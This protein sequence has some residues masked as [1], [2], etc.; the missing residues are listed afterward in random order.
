MT[1]STVLSLFLFLIPLLSPPCVLGE[2]PE[3]FPHGHK[4][5]SFTL[6]L[7]ELADEYPDL[8]HLSSLAQS[9]EGRDVWLM[10]ISLLEKEQRPDYPAIL[11]TAGLEGEHLLGSE[12]ALAYLQRLVDELDE[13]EAWLKTTTV[14]LIPRLNPDAVEY[15]FKTPLRE[16][17]GNTKPIDADRDG[18]I[19]EDGPDDLNEDHLITWMRVK[20]PKG[21]YI[22]H[23]DEER[24]LVEADS[25]QGEKGQWRLL[26]EGRDNDN[27]EKWNEDPLGEINFNRQF[28][29]HYPWFEAD[30]GVFQL[31][32]EIPRALADFILEHRHIAMVFS[33]ARND[34]LLKAPESGKRSPGREPQEKIRDE[35]LKY[36]EE[37]G[38]QYREALGL[39]KA[40]D[41]HTIDG[42]FTDWMYFH[43]G[44]LSLAAQA[45][46]PQIALNRKI[47]EDEERE[48]DSENEDEEP[49]E[50]DEETQ[51]SEEE[52][53]DSEEKS[54]DG[55]KKKE[56][57]QRGKEERDFLAWIE[58]YAP[59]Y[60]L[61]W[62]DYD[63]P[64][65]QGQE[66]QIGGW[67]PYAKILPPKAFMPEITQ[68]H[69]SFLLALPDK[70]PR[71]IIRKIEVQSLGKEVF[72]IKVHVR[73]EGYLPTML[74]HG[75][76]TREIL[77]TRLKTSLEDEA[78]LA[79]DPY[80]RF[81]PIAGGE[82][83]EARYIVKAEA[84]SSITF[85]LISALAGREDKTIELPNGD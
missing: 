75:E 71:L 41:H 26:R 46:N 82:E 42:S 11:I 84:G 28:P 22:L 36:Y 7:R 52:S 4:Y 56:E 76:R 10:E 17:S 81:G 27:D 83:K 16:Q 25:I 49:E 43:R 34:N 66:V 73:N 54:E 12:I 50:I 69:T 39:E 72:E 2:K 62:K 35:D 9:R 67:L 13:H 1:Q 15:F 48:K 33:F 65:F 45:W 44:R 31:S 29:F 14:Y 32:E 19:D 68:A 85:T 37:L 60:F 24:V 58:E 8:L 3:V 38:K 57:D 77:P 23:P 21:K 55:E 70:L 20:D 30:A 51:K 74:A 80:T 18:L 79:G 64:D 47:K 5:E 59:G 78:I 40:L 63:H 61:E 53:E 6:S